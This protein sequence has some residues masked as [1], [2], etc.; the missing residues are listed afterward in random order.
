MFAATVGAAAWA[1]LIAG[2]RIYVYCGVVSKA[3]QQ[4][5]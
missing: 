4:F 3:A 1:V 2:N 5:L